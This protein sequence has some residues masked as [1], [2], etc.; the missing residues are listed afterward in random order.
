M[1]P[2]KPA[3]APQAHRKGTYTK[4]NAKGLDLHRVIDSTVKT[5]EH[6]QKRQN[7]YKAHQNVF[8]SEF[9]AT[10]AALPSSALGDLTN[11]IMPFF[12][13]ANF[14][15]IEDYSVIIPSLQLATRLLLHPSLYEMLRTILAH[16]PLLRLDKPDVNGNPMYEYPP[17]VSHVTDE[18]ITLL[19]EAWQQMTGFVTFKAKIGR[20]SCD[21]TT[22]TLDEQRQPT[23]QLEGL[24]SIVWYSPRVLEIL[25]QATNNLQK[26]GDVPLLAWRFTFAVQ[27]AHEVCHALVFAH[28]GHRVDMVTEPFFPGDKTAEI[29][30]KMEDT[31][32]G[33]HFA[34]LWNDDD[35]SRE[36]ALKYHIK[37]NGKPSDLLGIPVLW[38]WPSPAVV[39]AYQHHNC[40]LW[41]READLNALDSKEI[42]WR[43]PLSDLSKFFQTAF[44][45]QPNPPT[46]LDRKVG[47]VFDCDDKGKRTPHDEAGEKLKLR[48]P[49]GYK[50]TRHKAIVQKRVARKARVR[51]NA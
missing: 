24:S 40:G 17:G 42:G 12:S 34:F 30:F 49:E 21:A 27:L 6:V 44:W 32:F 13:A 45:H 7:A 36:G 11:D 19:H 33:G 14:P 43:V 4:P 16:G 35:P 9:V 50:L 31:L 47:F 20:T 51:K 18:Q 37:P 25:T 38:P 23:E 39:R 10:E 28:D 48:V 46:R 26:T 1:S 41:I 5:K 22:E 8:A 29:G 2:C 15:D 3:Q